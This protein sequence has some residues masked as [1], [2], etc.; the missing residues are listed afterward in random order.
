[1]R[2]ALVIAFA[3]VVGACATPPPSHTANVC[4][5]FSEKGGLFNNW[6]RVAKST[7][8][9]FGV[10]VPILMATIKTESNFRANA[11][12]P[13]Q[14]LF[15]VIP[16][17]RASSA[18][19][20]SQALDGT[21]DWYRRATGRT[22]A[23]RTSFSDSIHFVGWYHYQSHRRNRVALNDAYRLYLNYYAGHAGF[24]RGVWRQRPEMQRA[25]R[26]KANI[27]QR[28]AQQMQACGIS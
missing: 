20:Y 22:S 19:G 11:R 24:K 8:R 17:K 13:R 3:L 28:Y 4:A 12:P 7:E 15:G 26:R 14:K 18:Y 1:M 16:W 9:E 21:W 6:Y 10:P 23:R 27:A 2:I 5:I 25:A